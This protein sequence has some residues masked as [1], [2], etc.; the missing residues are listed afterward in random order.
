MKHDARLKRI[1]DISGINESPFDFYG[2]ASVERDGFT[3]FITP[4]FLVILPTGTTQKRLHY[5]A[6]ILLDGEDLKRFCDYW[7]IELVNGRG[8]P[9][10]NAI[11]MSMG[12]WYE[13]IPKL[14]AKAFLRRQKASS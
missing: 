1:E 2:A 8:G 7:N 9:S 10:S 3:L 14:G 12:T 4:D 5:T 6:S 13:N 11:V